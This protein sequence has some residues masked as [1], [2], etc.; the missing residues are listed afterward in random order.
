MAPSATPATQKK[1][2]ASQPR[3]RVISEETRPRHIRGKFPRHN[4][5][6]F[7]KLKFIVGN[8]ICGELSAAMFEY[9]RVSL[10]DFELCVAVF[11]DVFI[12]NSWVILKFT[13]KSRTGKKNQ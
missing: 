11:E 3:A 4:R 10:N 5:G 2:L 1:H 7:H 13:F 8:I 6:A 9:Q 12:L